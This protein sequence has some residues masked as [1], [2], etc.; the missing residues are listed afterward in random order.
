MDISKVDLNQ[1]PATKSYDAPAKSGEMVV[2]FTEPEIDES[3]LSSNEMFFNVDDE[4]LLDKGPDHVDMLL[5]IETDVET[6]SDA[7]ES[8]ENFAAETLP[9]I[10]D[11]GF[12]NAALQAEEIDF[13]VTESPEEA[14]ENALDF[15]DFEFTAAELEQEFKKNSAEDALDKNKEGDDN[16]IEFD[17][18]LPNKS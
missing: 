2:E 5:D 13:S 1:Q 8:N 14:P 3:A 15:E 11:D 16:S 7:A 6:E 9:A 10:E 4:T 17:W 12:E 18:D